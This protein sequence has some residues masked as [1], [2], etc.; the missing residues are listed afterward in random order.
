MKV[1][2]IFFLFTYSLKIGALVPIEGIIYGEVQDIRQYDPFAGMLTANYFKTTKDRKSVDKLIYYRALFKQGMQLGQKCETVNRANYS[3][4]WAE[5]NAKRSVIATLQYIGLDLTIKSIINYAK[6]FELSEDEF[7]KLYHNLVD[8]NCSQNITVYSHK[9]LKSN[10]KYLYKNGS[11]FTNPELASSPYFNQDVKEKHDTR[12]VIKREFEYSLKNF[13]AF[14]SWNSDTNNLGLLKPYIK[15]PF[16]MSYIFNNLLQKKVNIDPKTEEI[17]LEPTSGGIQVACENMICRRRTTSEFTKYFPRMN[18]SYN[19]E[20]DLS[21]I[22]CNNF[23]NPRANEILLSNKMRSWVSKQS[24]KQKALESMHFLSLITGFPDL[25]L[26]ADTYPEL[27]EFFKDNIRQRWDRWA[28]EKSNQF[29]LEQLY[30]EPLQISMESQINTNET[31]LGEFKLKFKLEL[32]EMDKLLNDHDKIST[33]F[34]F[35]LPKE[36]ILYLRQR[37]PFL[38]NSGRKKELAGLEKRFLENISSQ[39]AKRKKYFKVPIWNDSMSQFMAD[40]L[41][42]Q[43]SRVNVYRFNQ[44]KEKMIKIPVNF[45]FGVFALQ[46]IRKKYIHRFKKPLT[47]GFN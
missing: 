38:Y 11:Q 9:M 47:A 40:E 4:Y 16:I 45:Y 35:E 26:I 20:D 3:N 39:L 37:I 15:N 19:L 30:E 5:E 6:K 41:L 27:L 22:Y 21:M 7:E 18:G 12:E 8:N 31:E 36:Y 46:Y 42:A 24:S 33:Q 44:K 34:Y 25:A 32:G 43:F 2:T 28:D 29:N 10:F 17:F 1:L 14:C 13:R 23:Q